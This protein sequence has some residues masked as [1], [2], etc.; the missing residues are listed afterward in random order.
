MIAYSQ[1]AQS[2]SSPAADFYYSLEIP[3]DVKARLISVTHSDP[4]GQEGYETPR[5]VQEAV[6]KGIDLPQKYDNPHGIKAVNERVAARYSYPDYQVPSNHVLMEKGNIGAIYRLFTSLL[7][8]GDNAVLPAPSYHVYGS[9]LQSL[10]AEA[11]YYQLEREHDW[12]VNLESLEAAIDERT[13]LVVVSNPNNPCGGVLS[14][15]QL[16]G[17][18]EICARKHIVVLSD[19]VY[20]KQVFDGEFVSMG[21]L[22]GDHPVIV[23]DSMDFKA[24]AP[25]WRLAWTIFYDRHNR[26]QALRD[27]LMDIGLIVTNPATFMMYS[28]ADALDSITPAFFDSINVRLKASSNFIA[29]LAE[30]IPAVSFTRPKGSFVCLV[31]LDL[32]ALH[33][34]SSVQ[35][36]K[37]FAEEDGVIV[38]PAEVF[39]GKGGFRLT[40]F[41]SNE[42]LTEIFSRLRSLV[43]R[44]LAN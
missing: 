31:N 39:G 30:G 12:S 8:E 37:R 43:L 28:A 19:E 34:E 1:L 21:E 42:I 20:N 18:L 4:T 27:K 17:V 2:I 11:K 13:R 5:A 22:A 41:Q 10:N 36:C 7:D 38:F 9:I 40:L 44:I 15:E 3:A 16:Q 14:R 6:A 23:L 33:L 32:E 26:T 35:F 29:S 24:M 25:G